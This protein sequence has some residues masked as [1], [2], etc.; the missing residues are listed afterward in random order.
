MLN[1]NFSV[2]LPLIN[3]AQVK[4]SICKK[5]GK[6]FNCSENEVLRKIREVKEMFILSKNP[7]KNLLL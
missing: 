6:N 7:A 4:D 2:C 5:I 1:N 3:S